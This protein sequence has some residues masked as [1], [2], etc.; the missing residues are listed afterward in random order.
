MSVLRASAF[1]I[2]PKCEKAASERS[3]WKREDF[4]GNLKIQ[5][6][7]TKFCEDFDS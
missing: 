2:L 3:Y 4:Y 5:N 7:C 6:C 1:E